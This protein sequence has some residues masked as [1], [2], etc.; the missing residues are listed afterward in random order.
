VNFREKKTVRFALRDRERDKN[1]NGKRCGIE[2]KFGAP[3]VY[4]LLLERTV[5]I[6]NKKQFLN[7]F[8]THNMDPLSIILNFLNELKLPKFSQRV[9]IIFSY[10]FGYFLNISLITTIASCTT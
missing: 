9:E 6:G 8:K 4:D 3:T 1:S 10:L 7:I 2:D 5:T